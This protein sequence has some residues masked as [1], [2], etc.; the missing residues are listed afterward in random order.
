MRFQEGDFTYVDGIANPGI[1]IVVTTGGIGEY[2]VIVELVSDKWIYAFN[3]RGEELDYPYACIR[4]LTKLD[5]L[6]LGLE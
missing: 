5:K 4:P 3:E 6:L 2:N 1:A